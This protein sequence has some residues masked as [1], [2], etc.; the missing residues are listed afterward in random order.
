MNDDARL[1]LVALGV[2]LG[3]ADLGAGEEGGNN[4]GP[5]IAR[6]LGNLDPPLGEGYPWCAAFVQLVFDIAAR[7]LGVSNPLDRVRLEAYVQD[8]YETLRSEVVRP[9]LVLPGYLV[10]YSFGGERFDH[11]GI[12][13]KPPKVGTSMFTAAEGNTGPGVG[14]TTEEQE[15]DGDGVF[16]RAR[17]LDGGYDVIFIDPMSR[18]RE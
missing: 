16:V 11:I 10:L 4:R 18:V 9:D 12:V 15:R 5:I 2:A 6:I 17:Q 13:T 7:R 8:Y 14:A 1:E 3:Y